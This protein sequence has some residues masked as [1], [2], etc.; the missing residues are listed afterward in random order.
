MLDGYAADLSAHLSLADTEPCRT[1]RTRPSTTDCDHCGCPICAACLEDGDA[2]GDRRL[3]GMLTACPTRCPSCSV[4][5]H[6][7]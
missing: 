2:G 4:E 3:H 6:R 5:A 1:C 7:T